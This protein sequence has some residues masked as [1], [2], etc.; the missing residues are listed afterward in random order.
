MNPGGIAVDNASNIY[1]ADTGNDRVQKFD[2]N[3]TF[4]TI[5]GEIGF[6]AFG[7]F[8]RPEGVAVDAANNVYVADTGNNRVQK[9]DPNGTLLAQIGGLGGIENGEYIGDRGTENGQFN[10]PRG[11]AVDSAGSV[12]VADS[13]NNRIQKFV[14][15]E[16]TPIPTVSPVKQV[17]GGSAVPRDLNGDG[18]YSDV[19]GN[20]G[21]DFGDVVLYFN[22]MDWIAANEPVSVFD[23][24][25]N[26]QIDFADIVWLF[27][28][29]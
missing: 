13:G 1:V 10:G 19:N 7:P 4:D 26:G 2:P 18:K 17:P 5:F 24:D 16:A 23:Y 9:F 22:Q 11:I 8:T 15:Q 20:G 28:T 29:I 25:E 6:P 12:Y 14:K 21:L 3:G 27:N